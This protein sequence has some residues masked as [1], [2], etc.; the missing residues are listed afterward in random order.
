MLAT[1]FVPAKTLLV[2][3]RGARTAGCVDFE[4]GELQKDV[5]IWD[6]FLL[7]SN[8]IYLYIDLS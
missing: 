4:V 2:A 7:I 8:M 3:S 6:V 5:P 1:Y